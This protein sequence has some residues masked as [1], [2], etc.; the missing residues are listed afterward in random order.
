MPRR[1]RSSSPFMVGQY[2]EW[3]QSR[4]SQHFFICFLSV[5]YCSEFTNHIYRWPA[6]QIKFRST[7]IAYSAPMK[8]WS[9]MSM[10][11]SND[12][13]QWPYRFLFFLQNSHRLND[14][15]SD[16]NSVLRSHHRNCTYLQ[17]CHNTWLWWYTT[18]IK[19]SRKYQAVVSL[20]RFNVVFWN[21]FSG[22]G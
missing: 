19:T 16:L 3:P 15:D 12:I 6:N 7:K 13:K 22:A 8:A 4:V 11:F 5:G 21:S 20:L 1:Q 18:W 17:L 2:R 14:T 9:L 10:W